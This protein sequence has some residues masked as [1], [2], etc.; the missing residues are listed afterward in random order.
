MSAHVRS[1]YKRTEIGVIPED[2]DVRQIIETCDFIVPGRNKPNVFDGN[3]PWITTPDL[4]DG[5]SVKESRLGLR[6]SEY[7]AKNVGSKIVPAGSILMS[8]VGDLGLVAYAENDIVINQQL[9]AFIPTA[10]ID[11]KFL[12]YAI[13]TRV[14]YL[15]TVATKTALPYLNK[16]N[17]NSIKIPF[18]KL[19]EQRAIATTL[20]DI[21]TLIIGLDKLIAKKRDIK[22]ATMQQLRPG[23][24]RLQGF[25]GEW[26]V[27]TFEE[28]FDFLSTATN[29]RSDLSESG[30]TY[31]L[32]YG[33]IHTRFHSHLDL[34]F[35]QP[36][37]VERAMC[38]SAA[39]IRNGDWVMADASEDFAGVGKTI[40]VSGLTDDARMVAG[41][42]TFLLREKTPT[43]AAGF[44]GHL[45]NL[46]SL[47]QQYLRVATGMKVYGVSKNALKNL[48]LPV[49]KLEEQTAIATILSDMDGELATIKA[50]C[51]KARQIKLGMMQELLTGRIRLK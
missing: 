14:D 37:K 1:G 36:P 7:E 4:T 5:G 27:K 43:F 31:Y 13:K 3:I 23:Q 24:Q 34:G 47:R 8:C 26:N 46:D 42:H 39:Y 44:K 29:A 35:D 15:Y 12:S 38:Q 18:P 32:H 22:Q 25:S 21:D 28:I 11:G 30:D 2:W 33:D 9:H 41:L 51:D 10:C 19:Q 6:V 50:R 40:E 20:S 48:V 17:C 49:P 16:D 45:G